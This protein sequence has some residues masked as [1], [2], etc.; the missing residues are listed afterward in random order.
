MYF[1]YCLMY[2]HD[3]MQGRA[4]L[5]SYGAGELRVANATPFRTI[6]ELRNQFAWEE[7][8]S[9]YARHQHDEGMHLEKQWADLHNG[10]YGIATVSG[11]AAISLIVRTFTKAWEGILS[12]ENI[13]GTSKNNLK[14]SATHD[15]R[16]LE[17]I[18]IYSTIEAWENRVKEMKPKIVFLESPS[19]PL[20]DLADIESLA[21]MLKNHTF[22]SNDWTIYSPKLV[23][24]STFLPPTLQKP[25]DLGADFTIDSLTKF[26]SGDNL[27]TWGMIV[28]KHTDDRELLFSVRN[29]SGNNITAFNSL[30]LIHGIRTLMERTLNQSYNAQKVAK[31]LK[32]QSHIESVR[33]LWL[34]DHPQNALARSQF[35][36]DETGKVLGFGNM[37]AFTVRWDLSATERVADESWI[38]IMANLGLAENVISHPAGSTHFRLTPE[39]R[40]NAGIGDNLLRLSV[41]IENPGITIEKL[42]LWLV[43]MDDN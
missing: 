24:D 19:N 28:G 10:N 25:L 41:W 37:I 27:A 8:L 2:S 43:A 18:S 38:A 13:F 9:F 17:F 36:K 7:H 34:E 12:S 40:K 31:W 6:A 39:E 3:S 23:V 35:V 22:K 21:K 1:Y 11:E 33:Y 20:T 15:G 26:A 29:E 42:Q 14:R 16:K 32:N 5:A 4:A 30:V